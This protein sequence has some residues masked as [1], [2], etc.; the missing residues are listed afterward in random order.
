[1][2]RWCRSIAHDHAPYH[3]DFSRLRLRSAFGST[4]LKADEL[5]AKADLWSGTNDDIIPNWPNCL[6]NRSPAPSS[7]TAFSR[8]CRAQ[9]SGASPESN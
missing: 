1:M 7:A 5:Y 9:F 8:R 2:A 6:W 4:N 3:V